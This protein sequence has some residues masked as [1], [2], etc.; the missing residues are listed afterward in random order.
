MCQRGI[1]R[2]AVIRTVDGRVHRGVIHRVT[3]D[4]VY[5]RPMGGRGPRGYGGFGY[6]YRPYGYGGWGFGWGLGI[7]I[8]L[9]VIAT[10]AFVPFFI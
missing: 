6:P 7:G 8:G 5:L 4:K 9:G 2:A 10:L 1:G 3:R